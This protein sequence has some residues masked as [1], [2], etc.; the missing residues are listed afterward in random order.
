MAETETH[1]GISDP[2]P[3]VLPSCFYFIANPRNKVSRYLKIFG[4]IVNCLA[5]LGFSP[6]FFCGARR[7][8][9][10]LKSKTGLIQ[11][12]DIHPKA[13]SRVFLPIT[14]L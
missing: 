3:Q 14:H 9:C 11:F 12:Q 7:K 6:I 10:P 4:Q 5:N 8:M 2:A 1:T 13:S